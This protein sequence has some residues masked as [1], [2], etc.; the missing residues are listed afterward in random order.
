MGLSANESITSHAVASLV[1]ANPKYAIGDDV[2]FIND[3]GVVFTDR[4]IIGVE[5]WEGNDE[6]RYFVEPSDSPWFSHKESTLYAVGDDLVVDVVAGHKIRNTTGWNEAITKML[7][8]FVVGNSL[9]IFRDQV[10][11]TE[12]ALANPVQVTGTT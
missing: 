4:K 8:Y 6:F 9:G 7:N 10:R 5:K 12:F 11:A 1:A 3:Y 2:T